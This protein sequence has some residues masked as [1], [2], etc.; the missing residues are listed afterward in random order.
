LGLQTCNDKH[1][2]QLGRLH[3]RKE[4]INTFQWARNA[5]FDNISLDLMFAL[6][7]QTVDELEDDLHRYLE[8]A[9]E[10]LSCYGLTA[11]P[12][13]PFEQKVSSGELILPDED[14]YADAFM[15]VHEQLTTAG[16]GHYE[17]AN[18]ARDG[19]ACQ[20]NSAYWQRQPYLGIG[21][22]AHSFRAE[23]WGSRHEVPTELI[24]YQKALQNQQT[25]TTEIESFDRNSA[26]RETVYLALR[27]RRG[28]IDQE[29]QQR[30][31]CTLEE[32]FPEA[33]SANSQWLINN[34]GQWSLTPSGWL[35]F[36]SLI[37]HF[38]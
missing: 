11:E 25:P 35:L 28:I 38:L 30:F 12:D 14:F 27:T 23:N 13:T 19:F 31:N 15:L 22:G 9:P 33:I 34:H 18:Y 17:I 5:G 24:S 4:G 3:N 1:L 32:A 37:L 20:H 21:T 26:L 8:L 2:V 10:H 7:G 29:L 36:D 16:Y 6:P